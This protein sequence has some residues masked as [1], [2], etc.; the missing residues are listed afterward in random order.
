MLEAATSVANIAARPAN[1]H[2]ERKPE[3]IKAMTQVLDLE[4]HALLTD[5]AGNS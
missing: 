5:V 2:R 1:H 4:S 3:M